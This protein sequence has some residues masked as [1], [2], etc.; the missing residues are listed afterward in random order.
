M[1]TRDVCRARRLPE[2]VA[3]R[4]AQ[5]IRHL[6]RTGEG[7]RRRVRGRQRQPGR[8]GAET[9]PVD[10]GEDAAQHGDPDDPA[11]LLDGEVEGRPHT[12]P[13]GGERAEHGIHRRCHGQAEAEADGRQPGEEQPVAAARPEAQQRDEAQRRHGDP[14]G[15]GPAQAGPGEQGC[16]C[17]GSD[18]ERE[19]HRHEL[20]TGAQCGVALHGLEVERQAEEQA[21]HHERREGRGDRR[22]EEQRPAQQDP[23]EH[24]LGDAG[25][26]D[27]ERREEDDADADGQEDERLAPAADR[28]LDDAVDDGA[29]AGDDQHGPEHVRTARGGVPRRWH[30]HQH[31]GEGCAGERDV[32]EHRGAPPVV[33][34]QPAADDRPERHPDTEGRGDRRH[35]PGPVGGDEDGGDD[36][37]GQREDRGGADPHEGP[38][39]DES[40][41]RCRERRGDGGQQEQAQA[42]PQHADPPEPVAEGPGGDEQGGRAEGVPVDDP[43]ELGRAGPEGTGDVAERDVEDGRVQAHD[44]DRQ[45]QGGEDHPTAAA[46]DRGGM[47]AGRPGAGGDHGSGHDGLLI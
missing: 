26:D 13:A 43:L 39:G 23:V 14:G 4:A 1:H 31:R 18:D 15:D 9:R 19:H 20:D 21:H 34:E 33:V 27:R 8:R 7:R 44:E 24:R 28:G 22:P 10:A 29:Q 30:E 11:G 40:A 12:L 38:A 32:D 47:P 3:G 25:L 16:A 46:A 45:T 35:R 2:S 41:R 17:A 42:G 36:R 6:G 37:Q 5:L